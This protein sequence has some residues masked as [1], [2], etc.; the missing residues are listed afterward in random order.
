MSSQMLFRLA[1]P[2]RL[3]DADFPT[4]A[5]VRDGDWREPLAFT[6][7]PAVAARLASARKAGIPVELAVALA[8]ERALVLADAAACGTGRES[9]EALLDDAASRARAS[10]VV[11]GPGQID[12]RYALSLQRAK[13][14]PWQEIAAGSVEVLIP[15]RLH[16]RGAQIRLDVESVELAALKQARAWE[17]AAVSEGM[18]LSEW[19]KQQQLLLA[20]GRRP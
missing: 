19:A 14:L 20:L 3:Q 9:L 8:I 16:L 13:P 15:C 10:E 17:I 18:L 2:V 1:T 11:L 7:E 5:I 12:A 4:V 6:L